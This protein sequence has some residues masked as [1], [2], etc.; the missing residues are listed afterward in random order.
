MVLLH[1]MTMDDAVHADDVDDDNQGKSHYSL[2]TSGFL[3]I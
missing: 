3:N 1:M 2:L